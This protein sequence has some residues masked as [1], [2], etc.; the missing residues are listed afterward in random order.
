[1]TVFCLKELKPDFVI[2]AKNLPVKP[3]IWRS[4]FRGLI[5][6]ETNQGLVFQIL[7]NNLI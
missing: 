6:V 7:E 5:L 2:S 3:I 1:M 4:W